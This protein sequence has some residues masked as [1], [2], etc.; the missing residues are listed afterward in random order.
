MI[1]ETYKIDDAVEHTN[2]HRR[3]R[4]RTL[5]ACRDGTIEM[6]VDIDFDDIWWNSHHVRKLTAAESAS[7]TLLTQ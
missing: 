4:I 6:Q 7:L 3:G 1:D 2:S 5:R